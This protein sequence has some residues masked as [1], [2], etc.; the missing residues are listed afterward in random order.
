MQVYLKIL[1]YDI[2]KCLKWSL[3]VKS[4]LDTLVNRLFARCVV[5]VPLFKFYY[6]SFCVLSLVL[7]KSQPKT[8]VKNVKFLN[9]WQFNTNSSVNTCIYHPKMKLRD[10]KAFGHDYMCEGFRVPTAFLP[11]QLTDSH[12]AP[13]GLDTDVTL[14]HTWFNILQMAAPRAAIWLHLATGVGTCAGVAHVRPTKIFYKSGAHH[15]SG[16]TFG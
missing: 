9:L 4:I 13:Q 15:T 7:K 10:G 8:F 16:L 14:H 11:G 5:Q 1:F 3:M 6:V 2:E 12:R